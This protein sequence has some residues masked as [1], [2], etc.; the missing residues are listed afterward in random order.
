MLSKITYPCEHEKIKVC[1]SRT[2]AWLYNPNFKWRCHANI[3]L[4]QHIFEEIFY[5]S[6]SLK[7]RIIALD[8]RYGDKKPASVLGRIYAMLW[9]LIGLILFSVFTAVLATASNLES[10]Q[11]HE[12]RGIKV[13]HQHFFGH[14][15]LFMCPYCARVTEM[16]VLYFFCNRCYQLSQI[17]CA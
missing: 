14:F 17:K 6:S 13:S 7:M 11:R 2:I 5:F 12:V 1:N 4:M 10:V 9:I 8:Y 3:D 15:A 16:P